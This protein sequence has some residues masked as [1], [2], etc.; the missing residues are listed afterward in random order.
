MIDHSY[1]WTGLCRV[2]PGGVANA[3]VGHKVKRAHPVCVE[4]I[5]DLLVVISILLALKEARRF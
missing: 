1:D 4:L 2:G 3:L 5:G